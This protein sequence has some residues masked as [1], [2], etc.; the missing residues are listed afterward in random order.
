MHILNKIL[1]SIF[2]VFILLSMPYAEIVTFHD[3]DNSYWLA[4]ELPATYGNFNGYDMEVHSETELNCVDG[5]QMEI[6]NDDRQIE[7]QGLSKDIVIVPGYK[8]D[9]SWFDMNETISSSYAGLFTGYHKKKALFAIKK[10]PHSLPEPSTIS[11]VLIGLLGMIGIATR[12]R[13]DV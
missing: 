9:I 13:K 4:H 6:F 10:L 7:A 2:T 5:N 3:F 8:N 1:Y 11:L 12:K